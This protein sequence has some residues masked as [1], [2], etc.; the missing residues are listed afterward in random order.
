MAI[1]LWR[2]RVTV[3]TC[4]LAG[5]VLGLAATVRQVGEILIVPALLFVLAGALLARQ[6][7]WRQ[8]LWKAAALTL[9]FAVPIVAYCAGS[10]VDH[11]ELLA[12][13]QRLPGHLRADGRGWPT[14]PR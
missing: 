11:R 8:A 14:A 7:G 12:V 4:V 13:P 9:A 5:G 10:Y 1:L 6:G 3:W 2:P